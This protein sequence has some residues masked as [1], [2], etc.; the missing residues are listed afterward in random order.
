LR[1]YARC[2]VS[3]DEWRTDFRAVQTVDE[4]DAPV[5]TLRSFAVEDG[6]SVIQRA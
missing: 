3:P 5:T 2:T 1:G 4:P 6:S